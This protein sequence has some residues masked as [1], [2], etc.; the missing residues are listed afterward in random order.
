[1]VEARQHQAVEIA[2]VFGVRA[3][4]LDA[5]S[6]SGSMT[7]ASLTDARRDLVDFTL[8]PYADAF[9]GRMSMDD[10]TETTRTVVVRLDATV[11]R[12]SFADRMAAYAAAQAAGIY[13]VDE[14]RDAE[15]RRPGEMS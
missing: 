10:V 12:A 14:L 6:P 11:L 2:R 4:L 15:R 5:G 3:A 9:A 8:A 1:M 13:T 7:Y